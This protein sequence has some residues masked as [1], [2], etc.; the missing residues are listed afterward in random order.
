MYLLNT[1]FIVHRLAA[2]GFTA[3]ARSVYM[4]AARE[5]K[6]FETV[7]LVRILTEVDPDTINYAV[8]ME[9]ASLDEAQRWHDE[10]ATILKD[11][12]AARMGDKV[13]SF[14]TFMEVME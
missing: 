4:P 6:L 3:W 2:D 1:T 7:R 9:A 11:D 13:L 14:T 5:S 10:T 8:Q 12:I